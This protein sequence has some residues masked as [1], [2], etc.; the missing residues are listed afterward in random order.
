MGILHLL[1]LLLELILIVC[2][3]LRGHRG[4]DPV[5]VALHA[6]HGPVHPEIVV[7]LAFVGDVDVEVGSTISSTLLIIVVDLI[8]L[9]VKVT[10]EVV[11]V[12]G[13]FETGLELVCNRGW[14]GQRLLCKPLIR[15]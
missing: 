5:H 6:T 2:C 9:L 13:F 12:A 11:I 15:P 8:I 1:I 7:Q 14:D 3:G 4:I 10:V